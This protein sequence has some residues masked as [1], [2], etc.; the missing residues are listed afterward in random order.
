M[1][2]RPLLAFA[3]VVLAAGCASVAEDDVEGGGAAVTK[4]SSPAAGL[5]R[6]EIA[7]PSWLDA[8]FEARYRVHAAAA[9]QPT[10]IGLP[11][12]P[13]PLADLAAGEFKDLTPGDYV[14]HVVPRG[15]FAR[16]T[17]GL[18]ALEAGKMHVDAGKVVSFSPA[19][20]AYVPDRPIVWGGGE[21]FLTGIS[22]GSGAG[23]FVRNGRVYERGDRDMI[24][25]LNLSYPSTL[26]SVLV[27]RPGKTFFATSGEEFEARAGEL[28]TFPVKTKTVAVDVDPVSPQ[29]PE[30]PQSAAQL[31]AS[32]DSH[33]PGEPVRSLAM[34]ARAVLPES[35]PVRLNVLGILFRG[36]L[37]GGVERFKLNRL[38]LDG[39]QVDGARVAGT[40]ELEMQDVDGR[41]SSFP[42]GYTL[43][44]GTGVDLPDGTYRLTTKA[45][46]ASGEVSSTE[47]ITFP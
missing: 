3:V 18:V 30:D 43:R 15:L 41:W 17:E 33:G 31:V 2:R 37:D 46:T 11:P 10:G 7:K 39:V 25:I 38:E 35:A 26:A 14:L 40:A 28:T 36:R 8:R 42:R 19:G 5:G 47:E 32:E 20:V 24:R 21:S 9:L 45:R 6:I 44:T 23:A 29:F 22:T 27:A 13:A 4:R 16:S 1:Y 12:P 34:F